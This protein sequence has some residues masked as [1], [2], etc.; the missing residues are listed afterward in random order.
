MDVSCVITQ[1][2]GR[3]HQ[4]RI[5]SHPLLPLMGFFNHV[6]GV[7]QRRFGHGLPFLIFEFAGRKAK[8]RRRAE[9]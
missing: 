9:V 1:K 4:S 3:R 5:M 7:D 6:F 8:A 2:S